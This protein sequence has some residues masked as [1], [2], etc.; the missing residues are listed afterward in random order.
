MQSK[1]SK[2]HNDQPYEQTQ[3][4]CIKVRDEAAIPV[5]RKCVGVPPYSEHMHIE[6]NL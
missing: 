4:L 1:A 2:W 6:T 5:T 3:K